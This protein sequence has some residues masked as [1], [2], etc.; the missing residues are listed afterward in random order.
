MQVRMVCFMHPSKRAGGPDELTFEMLR[1]A[2]DSMLGCKEIFKV[3]RRNGTPW[4]LPR[5]LSPGQHARDVPRTKQQTR[6]IS[7]AHGAA[8]ST[9][10]ILNI[11]HTT[12]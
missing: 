4:S 9:A 2:P 12:I 3:R 6:V 8:C 7:H 5:V 10:G 11:V 1:A